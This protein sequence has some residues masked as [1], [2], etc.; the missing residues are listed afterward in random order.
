VLVAVGARLDVEK[1]TTLVLSGTLTNQGV[2]RWVSGYNVFNLNGSGRV[3]NLGMWEIYA[4]PLGYY[5]SESVVRVP[6]NV[7]VGGKLW[8]STNAVANFSAPS[9]LSVAGELEV[10]SGA[11]LRLD[12]SNPARDLTLAFGCVWSGM[13]TTL[14]EGANRVVLVGDQTLGGGTL[15][16]YGS[17][18]LV[19]TNLFII[20]SGAA[21]GLDHSTTFPGSLTVNGAL[22]LTAATILFNVD[23]TLTLDTGGVINNPGTIRVGVFANNG[24][25]IVGN[26]PTIRTGLGP[27][28]IVGLTLTGGS[29]TQGREAM[30]AVSPSAVLDCR[31]LPGQN[32]VVESSVDCVHWSRVP[33]AVQEY[34]PGRF[35]ASV[36]MG[37]GGRLFF[38]LQAI[39]EDT[40][41][42]DP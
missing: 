13:G 41:L 39:T 5:G 3:E 30:A 21:V 4:D 37:N 32:F 8:L 20:A 24:G 25:I 33:T 2:M 15:N 31:G 29:Q 23:G 11:R 16:L 14:V 18:S 34:S 40:R 35:R 7:P 1:S 38:R 36:P 22:T 12:G 19:G 42:Q 6:V 28:S 17:S 9:S 10:Q 26:A 27:L